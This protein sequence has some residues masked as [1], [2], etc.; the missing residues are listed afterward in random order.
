M[1]AAKPKRL[2]HEDNPQ[3]ENRNV[4][5]SNAQEPSSFLGNGKLVNIGRMPENVDLLA[6][7]DTCPFTGTTV[8]YTPGYEFFREVHGRKLLCTVQQDNSGRPKFQVKETNCPQSR[9]LI[10]EQGYN[11]HELWNRIGKKLNNKQSTPINGLEAHGL[12][13]NETHS[14]LISLL[15][16]EQTQTSLSVKDHKLKREPVHSQN[17]SSTPSTNHNEIN[18]ASMENVGTIESDSKPPSLTSDDTYI[19]ESLQSI[20]NGSANSNNVRTKEVLKRSTTKTLK[21][22]NNSRKTEKKGKRKAEQKGSGKYG[23]SGQ[24][25]D[26]RKHAV[27]EF[28]KSLEEDLISEQGQLEYSTAAIEWIDESHPLELYEKPLH[29]YGNL[30]SL[31][32]NYDGSLLVSGSST[33][34]LCVW[35]TS[36]WERIG[37]FCDWETFDK[38]LVEYLTCCFSPDSR[39]IIAAGVTRDRFSWNDEEDENSVV[40]GTIRIFDVT[41]GRVTARLE[42]HLEE[43]F[44]LKVIKRGENF[45]L[46][47]CGE[48]GRICKFL[49]H[50]QDESHEQ[51]NFSTACKISTIS[52]EAMINDSEMDPLECESF[53]AIDLEFL[54]RT[55]NRLFLVAVDSGLQLFDFDRE[56]C[57][58]KFPNL[59]TAYAD[60]I[61]ILPVSYALVENS[62]VSQSEENIYSWYLVTRGVEWMDSQG[63]LPREN[64]CTLRR[65][66]CISLSE[67]LWS[68]ESIRDFSSEEYYSNIWPC[69][70]ATQGRYVVSGSITGETFVWHLSSGNLTAKLRGFDPRKTIRT[71]LFHPTRAL[72]V[73]AGDDEFIR[74]WQQKK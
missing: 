66:S 60:S 67:S 73:T 2:L 25:T 11:I 10:N 26:S 58:A 72:L 69:R 16:G 65:L 35:D 12:L 70:L 18:E 59:Y 40:P 44:C 28:H 64:C 1:P 5:N 29:H 13:S 74:I 37:E 6:F 55:N 14:G 3:K 36:S 47:S 45:Y 20:S 33:G 46:I 49:F 24:S 57:I 61:S 48:D 63:N 34:T 62:T 27:E 39:Y 17:S 38:E 31:N 68:L 8:T 56:I 15:E 23:G 32:F 71:I 54:P 52:V 4:S 41:S 42:G 51:F 50:H 43:I 53:I 9:S 30:Y 22:V 21:K 19:P 7:Q